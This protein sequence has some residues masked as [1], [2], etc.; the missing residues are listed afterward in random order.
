MG[1]KAKYTMAEL[2]RKAQ[3]Q[4]DEQRKLD[5]QKYTSKQ[6]R[7]REYH[8]KRRPPHSPAPVTQ[9][10]WLE[11]LNNE[12]VM[13]AQSTARVGQ[14]EVMETYG[15]PNKNISMEVQGGFSDDYESGMK[16]SWSWNNH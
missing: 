6:N 15:S 16:I 8:K 12:E 2:K 7:E 10:R 13:D 11:E 9:E 5:T 4:H 3:A 14:D 1:H